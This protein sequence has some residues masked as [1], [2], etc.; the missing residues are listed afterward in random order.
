M[1][2]NTHT[3]LHTSCISALKQ[4]KHG[5][6]RVWHGWDFRTSVEDLCPTAIGCRFL[7]PPRRGS[8][9]CVDQRQI[10]Q[11]NCP[12]P[13][14]TRGAE[15]NFPASP[16]RRIRTPADDLL[17]GSRSPRCGGGAPPLQPL[18][19]GSSATRRHGS[20]APG[21]SSTRRRGGRE[22]ETLAGRG[23]RRL[24]HGSVVSFARAAASPPR[25]RQR[26]LHG[27]GGSDWIGDW[28]ERV[29]S[30]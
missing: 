1:K 10:S 8:A 6:T 16:L 17:N 5:A 15:Q 19:R 28:F 22:E 9:P 23:A 25:Q 7:N 4:Q 3:T 26:L 24:L 20:S 29:I 13:T 11:R 21:S 12:P 27:D 2:H 18:R 30:I 14:R